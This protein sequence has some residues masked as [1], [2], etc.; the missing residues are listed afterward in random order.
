MAEENP[1]T[2]PG[3]PPADPPAAPK[4]PAQVKG[5][6]ERHPELIRLQKKQA[7]LEDKVS[8][9]ESVIGGFNEALESLKIGAPNGPIKI[10]VTDPNAPQPKGGFLSDVEKELWE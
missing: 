4:T 1:N 8:G 3:T 7:E 6:P 5:T 9:L 2:P 10:P